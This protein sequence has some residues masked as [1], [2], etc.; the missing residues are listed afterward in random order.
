MNVCYQR[1]ENGVFQNYN[2]V[3]MELVRLEK[4]R[5]TDR[6]SKIR[7]LSYRAGKKGKKCCPSQ[8]QSPEF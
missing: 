4:A 1:Q 8:K 7:Q 5:V 3:M 6:G 2:P